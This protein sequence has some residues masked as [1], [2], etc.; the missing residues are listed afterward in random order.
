[1]EQYERL[2]SRR[3]SVTV[4]GLRELTAAI[5]RLAGQTAHSSRTVSPKEAPTARPEDTAAW[6]ELGGRLQAQLDD[7]KS[8]LA[9]IKLLLT[10]E[11]G[12]VVKEAYTVEEVAKK[13]GYAL[14]TLRQACNKGRIE[15][16]YKGRDRAW[17][18]PHAVV[19]DILN[20]GLPSE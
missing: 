2:W 19:Q 14:F 1:M 10:A 8:E 20:N 15:G 6:K 16:T 13:T 7:V 12:E 18:I 5:E 9:E 17:R 3:R 4:R 11:R